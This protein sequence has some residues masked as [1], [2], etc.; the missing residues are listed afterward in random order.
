VG[1]K[2]KFFDK[3]QIPIGKWQLAG[4]GTWL[5]VLGYWYLVIGE[6]LRPSADRTVKT[7]KQG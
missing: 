4:A 6:A 3:K 1:G 7:R 5:L 2:A